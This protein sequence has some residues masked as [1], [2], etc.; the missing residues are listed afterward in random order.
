M[1]LFDCYIRDFSIPKVL[2]PLADCMK[3]YNRVLVADIKAFDKV[4][5]DLKEKYN[6]IP[7]AE[8]RFLFKVSEGPLGVISVHRNNSTRKYILCLYFTPVRGMF[9]F[10]SSQESIQSVPDDGDEYY[11]L[12]DHIKSSVQ[13]GGAK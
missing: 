13:K 7:K 11:S 9:G 6:A 4:V 3:S 8:E 5:E 2:E 12:P 10:D 1:I